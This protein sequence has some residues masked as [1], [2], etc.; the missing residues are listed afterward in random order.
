MAL[1]TFDFPY[2]LY[3]TVN[4]ETGFRGQFGGSY[5]FTATPDAPDQRLFKLTFEAMKFFTNEDGSI[6][7]T[8]EP[9]INMKRLIDF[10]SEHKLHTTFQYQHPIHGL[11]VVKFN[12]PV[13]EPKGLK[14][15]GGVV[16]GFEVELIEI[17]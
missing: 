16:E 13:P 5:V 14:G 6:N 11:M 12:K 10:Y 3:E 17:P 9:E 8:L 15:G 2:H 4:P 7:V 1:Q